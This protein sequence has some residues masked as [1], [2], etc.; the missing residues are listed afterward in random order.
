MLCVYMC[1]CIRVHTIIS[2]R[3]DD[4]INGNRTETITNVYTG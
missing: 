1:V 4:N 2:T 3:N